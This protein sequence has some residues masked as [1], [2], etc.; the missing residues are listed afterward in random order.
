M[1][2]NT[3]FAFDFDFDFDPMI[4]RCFSL[5]GGLLEGNEKPHNL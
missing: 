2:P 4:Y 3:R 5:C 1:E